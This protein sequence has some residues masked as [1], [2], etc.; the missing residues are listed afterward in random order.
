MNEFKIEPITSYYNSL[1]DID[2]KTYLDL[3]LLYSNLLYKYLIPKLNLKIYEKMMVNARNHFENVKE[4][5]MDFYQYLARDYLK[6]FYIRNN[7]YIERLTED[8]LDFLKKKLAS[9]NQDLDSKTIDFISK[10]YPKVIAEK[11][12]L[13]NTKVSYGPDNYDFYQDSK[14]LVIGVRFNEYYMQ[15]GETEAEWDKKYDNREFELD[16]ITFPLKR[17]LDNFEVKGV[18]VRYNDFSVDKLK[19]SFSKIQFELKDVPTNERD[20]ILE[21]M[22]IKKKSL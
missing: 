6:Y 2:K 4:D 19:N 7:L 16:N 18:V 22:N 17:T 3:Y 14:A 10:T 9:N 13:N 15:E 11:L 8:E 20:S 1:N 5:D 21:K 12:D